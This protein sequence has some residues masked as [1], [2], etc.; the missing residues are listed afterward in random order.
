MKTE[1]GT[2]GSAGTGQSR[3]QFPVLTLPARIVRSQFWRL[4]L[5]ADRDLPCRENTHGRPFCPVRSRPAK[6]EA[7]LN[8]CPHPTGGLGAGKRMRA[9]PEGKLKRSYWSPG[10]LIW[11]IIPKEVRAELFARYPG[12]A[13]NVEYPRQGNL[14]PLRYGLGANPWAVR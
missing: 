12:D 2:V 4:N 13:L 6:T 9:F 14:I 1:T 7:K 5:S 8:W 11:R 10:R 3:M